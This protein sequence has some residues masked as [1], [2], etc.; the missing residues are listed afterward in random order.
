M[1][2]K[3]KN[4][5]PYATPDDAMSIIVSLGKGCLIAEIYIKSVIC[6][7]PVRREDHELMVFIGMVDL[8]LKNANPWVLLF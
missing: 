7:V 2:L 3:L 6:L 1:I 5:V 4:K 8:T